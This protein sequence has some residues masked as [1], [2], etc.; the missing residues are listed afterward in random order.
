M[1]DQ[2]HNALDDAKLLKNVYERIQDD[3]PNINDFSEYL[4]SYRFPDQVRTV[5][6]LN[7]DI[8]LQEFKSLDDAVSWLKTQPNDKGPSYL[9]DAKEKIKKAAK[10]GG[11]YFKSTWRIL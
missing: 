1:E 4:D 7:G 2:N 10:E 5:L 8:I 9:K 3:K 11:K 6:R